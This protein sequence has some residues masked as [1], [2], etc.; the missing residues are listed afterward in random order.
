MAGIAEQLRNLGLVSAESE[1]RNDPVTLA[2][3]LKAFDWTWAY[4]D[5]FL[6]GASREEKRL[7]ALLK[8]RCCAFSWKQLHAWACNMIL[9]DFE[10]VAPDNFFRKGRDRRGIAPCARDE[11]ITREEADMIDAW[12]AQN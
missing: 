3:R 8:E 10:E 12:L 4:S 2:E 6:A 11:L 1:S 7:K 5:Q 9:E